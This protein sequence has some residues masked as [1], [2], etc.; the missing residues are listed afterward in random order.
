LLPFPNIGPDIVR[1]GPLR[2]RWYG[3]MYLAGFVASYF[4]IR[5]QKRAK[6]LGLQG[7]LLQ[8][9]FLFLVIGMILGA[10]LGY[11]LFYQFPNYGIYI[12]NPLEIIA[13]WHGG[14]SF[15]GGL[16]GTMLA[17]LLFCRKK[18]LPFWDV[19]DIVIVTAPIGLFL[20]RLGN[21]ING[22][23]FGRPSSVPWAML[24]PNGGPVARHP[25]QLY[26]AALEG[27]LLFLVLWRLKDLP[28]R[29][30]SMIC[31]FIGGYGFVR[32]F[33][34]FFREPDPQIGFIFGF[35]TMGQV[36]CSAMVVAAIVLWRLLPKSPEYSKN[37]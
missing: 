1:I 6:Q 22:E 31:F 24:F 25:S 35:M 27:V 17:G 11:I 16:V 4:L 15:H 19:G 36:L 37:N 5:R 8:D 33:V 10:R 29:P 14:M 30:G 2:V 3:L 34:E 13:L 20:G 9:L 26:E 23:L 28:F 32:F 12:K 18:G 21:F 7:S